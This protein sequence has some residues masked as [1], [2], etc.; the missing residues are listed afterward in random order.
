MT[1]QR[2][3]RTR[4]GNSASIF[5]LLMPTLMGSVAMGVDWGA[6]AVARMQ[7][8]A[9][10]DAAAVAATTDMV[11]QNVAEPRAAAYAAAMKINGIE[12]EVIEFAYGT[13]YDDSSTFV[14]ND[15]TDRNAVRIRTRAVLPMTF[16]WILGVSEVT[17]IA[18]SGAGPAVIPRRAPDHVLVLDVTCSMSTSEIDAEVLAAT[19]L[20]D[21][22]KGRSDPSSRGGVAVFTG[23]DFPV[24]YDLVEYG[25]S[26]YDDLYDDTAAIRKCN[27]GDMPPCNTNTDQATGL[28]SGLE[29][30][31]VADPPV[32]VD[33]GQVVILMSDGQPS[34]RPVCQQQ[35]YDM[36]DDGDV[37]FPLQE[38]CAALGVS[39]SWWGGCTQNQPNSGTLTQW[40]DIA[41]AKAIA[42]DVDVYTVYYGTNNSGSNFLNYHIRAN[43]GTHNVAT[44]PAEITEVFKEVCVEFTGGTAGMLW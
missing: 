5:A 20:L 33:V 3:Q 9:A 29:I 32:P 24:V 25:V 14:A 23:L 1:T 43:D 13:W 7:V 2:T 10:A 19:E 41:R 27:I 6:V 16:A 34:A 28:E 15:N 11:N 18:E 21:C 8:Q 44:T 26:S 42:R 22:V 36:E 30:L 39:C 38:R 4:R 17:I 37:L 31:D 35:Y 12:P 40:A